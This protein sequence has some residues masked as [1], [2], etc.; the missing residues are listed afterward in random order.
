MS[1]SEVASFRKTVFE[2]V[3]KSFNQGDI[4]D[5]FLQQPWGLVSSGRRRSDSV[6]TG[7]VASFSNLSAWS[8]ENTENHRPGLKALEDFH[9]SVK[10]CKAVQ[11]ICEQ[12]SVISRLYCWCSLAVGFR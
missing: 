10:Q 4:C 8:T 1:T 3:K 5:K 7:E 2:H 12:S 6:Q 11:T 9:S